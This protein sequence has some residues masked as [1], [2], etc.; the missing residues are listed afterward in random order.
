MK[1]TKHLLCVLL[2]GLSNQHT[3]SRCCGFNL[4]PLLNDTD[5]Y[6]KRCD[7]ICQYWLEILPCLYHSPC[8]RPA[9]PCPLPRNPRTYLGRNLSVFGDEV[10]L[11][12]THMISV[13]KTTL[14]KKIRAG[15]AAHVLDEIAGHRQHS[16]GVPTKEVNETVCEVE[17]V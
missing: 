3:C 16:V 13:E 10:A 6:R 4:R 11:D 5:L 8:L 7:S 14:N 9:Y 12:L 1:S 15:E 17:K 2:R